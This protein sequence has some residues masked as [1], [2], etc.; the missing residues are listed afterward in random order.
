MLQAGWGGLERRE[1]KI[2]T[3]ESRRGSDWLLLGLVWLATV[4][5]V[6]ANRRKMT[7]SDLCDNYGLSGFGM[8]RCRVIGKLRNKLVAPC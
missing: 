3:T 5:S 8:F 1:R 6:T 2:E 7:M 4:D